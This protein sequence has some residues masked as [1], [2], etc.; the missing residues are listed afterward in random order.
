MET[1]ELKNFGDIAKFLDELKNDQQTNVYKAL[2]N[3]LIE[4]LN[5]K[6]ELTCIRCSNDQDEFKESDHSLETFLRRIVFEYIENNAVNLGVEINKFR[7]QSA[8]YYDKENFNY[9]APTFLDLDT[10]KA[11]FDVCKN[12][13][14]KDKEK[15][16]GHVF[17]CI[18]ELC[19][20]TVKNENENKIFPLDLVI[21]SV[22]AR[23]Y[24]A[25]F[26]SIEAI[27]PFIDMENMLYNNQNFSQEDIYK[28]FRKIPLS[29]FDMF[30]ENQQFVAKYR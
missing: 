7:E 28:F 30:L 8:L 26:Y 2:N 10:T 23:D 12:N 1:T 27:F 22:N 6:S 14:F 16:D 20:H 29:C 3:K 17:G 25:T 9:C 5:E 13:L 19:Q 4:S 15:I 24:N 11:I 21:Y 18:A